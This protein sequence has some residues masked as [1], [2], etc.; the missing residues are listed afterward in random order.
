MMEKYVIGLDIG[1]TSAKAVLFKKNG[2][3]IAESE[4][5]Y[6]VSHPNPSW[7]EQDPIII[8][9]AAITAIRSVTKKAEVMKK[10][11]IAVGIST[12]MHSL[13]CVDDKYNPLSP[14][15][16]WADGRSVEQA[17]KL[18]LQTEI[19]LKTGTPIHPMSPFCKLVWMKENDYQP[20]KEAA[21]FVSIKEF[22]LLRWF[23]EAVV[24]YSV[25]SATGL[26]NIHTFDWDDDVLEVAGVT[27]NQLSKPVGP[28]A[29]CQGLTS[30]IANLL[31][32]ETD[33]P[34]VLAGSDGPLA[35]L[36]IGAI[37]PGDVA[38][39]VGTSGAIRQM[40]SKPQT[41]NRQ[42][43]FCYAVTEDRWIMGG[44]TNNGGIVFQWLRDVLGEKEVELA[45]T[46]GE[47]AYELLTKLA[48]T[49]TPGS[50]GLL[51]LPFLNGERAPYWDANAR[52]SFIGL[53]MA[54][55]KEHMIRAGLE[56]VV[57]SL[58]SVAE[59]L[60][61]LAGESINI[62]ASGGFARSPLWLQIVADIF[63][64]PVHVPKSHQS[65]A[66]GAAWFALLAVGEASSLE[67]IKD[68][69]PMKQTYEPN[70]LASN[71]YKELYKTYN[72]LYEV[73]KPHFSTIA[74]YQ[75]NVK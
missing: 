26:F 47:N 66:W 67:A 24:D 43:V 32:L 25:A 18:R 64:Q 30:E 22:L 74:N 8:E 45:L 12:A 46:K 44:P 1:T 58:Y 51:F 72:Q 68:S 65:S 33:T 2:S 56:G 70:N 62:F 63:G 69:I 17:N 55:K 5:G 61:R 15:I 23:G 27:R 53:T 36:G 20:Y 6:S 4:W 3:V 34:F 49:V 31:G 19:Y 16:I 29:I 28:T 73:L 38:I 37:A 40:A 39:T 48:S 75:R 21:M 57:F 41:D 59:A 7:S 14:S 50:D 13:I 52:G 35:N 11:V 9:K 60:E 54:H 71:H 42:E 10:Q